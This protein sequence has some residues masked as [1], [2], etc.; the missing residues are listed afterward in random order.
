LERVLIF[1]DNADGP[2]IAGRADG[3]QPRFLETLATWGLAEEVHEEGSL[4]ER[5]AIY[6]DSKKLLFKPSHQSDSRYR[7][8]LH[9]ITQGQVERIYIRDL[10]RHKTLVE[11]STTL[12]AFQ[13]DESTSYPVRAILRNSRTGAEEQVNA[14]FLVGSDGAASMVRK[15]LKIPFDGTSTDIYWAFWT[16]CLRRITL[17]PGYS[18][19]SSAQPMV[20]ASSFRE[21]TAI[22]GEYS[23]V[24]C[25][26]TKLIVPDCT[27]K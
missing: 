5:T 8:R 27:L 20:A 7:G 3:V 6:K 11:R 21:K 15:Q 22:S 18:A 23:D 26:A 10:I 17:M 9:I 25:I 2:L 19:L 12:S 13:V 1:T 24:A 14:K 4:I 16:A